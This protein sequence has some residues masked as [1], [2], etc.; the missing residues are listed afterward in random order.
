MLLNQNYRDREVLTQQGVSACLCVCRGG[1]CL[2]ATVRGLGWVWWRK[3]TPALGLQT[4]LWTV[5][6]STC[7]SLRFPHL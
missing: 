4:S 3:G 2:F 7:A 5:C 6:P 1:S